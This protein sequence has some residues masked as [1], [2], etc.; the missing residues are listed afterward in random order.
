MTAGLT[1]F[2]QEETPKQSA[3]QGSC[4]MGPQFLAP[5]FIRADFDKRIL[6]KP[7]FETKDPYKAEFVRPQFLS[8]QFVPPH[9]LPRQ[10]LGC[11]GN[12]YKAVESGY[13]LELQKPGMPALTAAPAAV[14]ADQPQLAVNSKPTGYH[15]TP[16]PKKSD[17]CGA[18]L[19]LPAPATAPATQNA[20]IN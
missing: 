14:P 6:D 3:Y 4:R 9:F 7:E 12:R 17:C 16:P 18:D 15:Y 11:T 20:K 5:Q 2:G 8:A 1:V 13:K 10:Y 19:K